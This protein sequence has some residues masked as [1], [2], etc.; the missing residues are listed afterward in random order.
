MIR[1]DMT[2]SPVIDLNVGGKLLE[3]RLGMEMVQ[4]PDVEATPPPHQIDATPVPELVQGPEV[5]GTNPVGVLMSN[6]TGL[7]VDPY[8]G[9]A[10]IIAKTIVPEASPILTLVRIRAN[11]PIIKF[12]TTNIDFGPMPV[13]LPVAPYAETE[14]GEGPEGPLPIDMNALPDAPP[15]SYPAATEFV[16]RGVL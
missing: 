8:E 13:M 4:A 16:P 7:E 9:P 2:T 5:N 6:E 1:L 11:R 12:L 15:A 14:E 3:I 10:S